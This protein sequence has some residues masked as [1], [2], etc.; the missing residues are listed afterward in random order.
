ML[1]ITIFIDFYAIIDANY[2]ENKYKYIFDF[3]MSIYAI[4]YISYI[5]IFGYLI[6]KIMKKYVKL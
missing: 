2:S 4:I 5:L 1:I 6:I 3:L